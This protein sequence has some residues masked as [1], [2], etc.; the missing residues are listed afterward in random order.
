M[1]VRGTTP[2]KFI[3]DNLQKAKVIQLDNYP[4][5]VRALAQGRGDGMIDIIDFVGEHMNKHQVKWKVVKTPVDVYYCG[6]GVAKNSTG[7]KDWLNV[8]I[9]DLHKKGKVGEI[10][11]KWFGIDMLY[12]TG[13]GAAF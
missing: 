8:A 11:K 2:I 9:F 10:W 7:L 3:E 6:L 13:V 5:A 4:D 1:Q 12:P